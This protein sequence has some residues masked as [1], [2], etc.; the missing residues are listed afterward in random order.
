MAADFFTE[1]MAKNGNKR[2]KTAFFAL[3]RFDAVEGMV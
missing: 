1:D 3:Q 2:A